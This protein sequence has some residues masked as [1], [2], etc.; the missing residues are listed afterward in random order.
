VFKPVDAVSPNDRIGYYVQNGK[1]FRF[2]YLQ[3]VEQTPKQ[4]TSDEVTIDTFK[5]FV[6]GANTTQQAINNGNNENK[7]G[8]TDTL[9]PF[10]TAVITGKVTAQDKSKTSVTFQLQTSITPRGI[11]N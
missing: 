9:Q 11:D 6:S 4:I 10:I 3:G 7:G 1:I 5:F 2:S 8:L